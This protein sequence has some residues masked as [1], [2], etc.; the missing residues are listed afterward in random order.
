MQQVLD[1]TTFEQAY[2][3]AGDDLLF[4]NLLHLSP[5]AN[6]LFH[7]KSISLNIIM[8]QTLTSYF[9]CWLESFS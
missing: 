6:A 9:L 2:P 5:N 1:S 7:E 8:S 3:E 4:E